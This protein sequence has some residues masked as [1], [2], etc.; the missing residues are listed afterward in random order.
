[1]IQI[2]LF[3]KF[4]GFFQSSF[5]R[6]LHL[7]IIILIFLQFVSTLYMEPLFSSYH[8]EG[9][10]I[11][12]SN[13]YHYVAGIISLVLMA[14]MTYACIATKGLKHY[15]PYLYFNFKTILKDFSTIFVKVPSPAPQG[16][17]SCIQGIGMIIFLLMPLTGF[18]WF[19]VYMLGYELPI[20]SDMMEYHYTLI[21]PMYIYLFIHGAMSVSHF[22]FWQINVKKKVK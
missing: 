17:S 14:L 11:T 13:M 9:D 3:W 20:T 1:M 4:L 5:V 2:K 10:E 7:A 8:E 18:I 6:S 15:F 21:V 12:F 16:I 22:I 19:V